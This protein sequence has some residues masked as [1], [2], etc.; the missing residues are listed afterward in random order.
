MGRNSCRVTA[1]KVLLLCIVAFFSASTEAVAVPQAAAGVDSHADDFFAGLQ[2]QESL[3]LD[4]MPQD[5]RGLLDRKCLNE[6]GGKCRAMCASKQSH[7]E[8]NLCV[9]GTIKKCAMQ[10]KKWKGAYT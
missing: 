6:N 3:Q 4:P 2:L 10:G 5:Q 7:L 1:M 8:C 9:R